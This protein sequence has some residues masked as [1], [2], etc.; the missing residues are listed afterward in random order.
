VLELVDGISYTVVFICGKTGL[1]GLETDLTSFGT[2]SG[3]KFLLKCRFVY[4]T[5]PLDDIRSF[6]YWH[7]LLLP[8]EPCMVDIPMAAR[9]VEGEF[10]GS[11]LG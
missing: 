2:D 11:V 10:V 9:K 8:I 5:P 1:T 6:H 7:C 4:S 3:L